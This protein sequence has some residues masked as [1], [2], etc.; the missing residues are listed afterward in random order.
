M[1]LGMVKYLFPCIHANKTQKIDYKMNVMQ[2]NLEANMRMKVNIH[3]HYGWMLFFIHPIYEWKIKLN[4]H[5]FNISNFH[6]N[7]GWMV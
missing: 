7:Y 5:V 6:Q 1:E 2:V 4:L 3:L